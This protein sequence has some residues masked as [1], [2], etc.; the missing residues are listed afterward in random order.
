ML[1]E[2]G[3]LSILMSIK[4]R[5]SRVS[6]STGIITWLMKWLL[7]R[8]AVTTGFTKLASSSYSWWDLSA[9]EHYLADQV[10]L[11]TCPF[12]F[13]VL[14]NFMLNL[15]LSFSSHP[16]LYRGTWALSRVGLF[17]SSRLL[18]LFGKPSFRSSALFQFMACRCSLSS[19]WYV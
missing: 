2:A 16:H 19:C 9:M 3:F 18:L 15:C 13:L 17:V 8:T 10:W 4:L 11:L 5:V 7:F 1:I 14:D 6:P 12:F